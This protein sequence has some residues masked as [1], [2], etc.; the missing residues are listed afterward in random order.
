MTQLES[1]K[2]RALARHGRV[3]P[4][5]GRT[6]PECLTIVEGVATLWYN[7]PDGSTHVIRDCVD[8]VGESCYTNKQED[9]SARH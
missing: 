4:V 8:T 9:T 1:L 7:S 6:W 2:L 5:A 3:Y